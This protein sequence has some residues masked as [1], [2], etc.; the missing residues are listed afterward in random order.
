MIY[1]NNFQEYYYSVGRNSKEE[2]VELR[3]KI[4]K[5]TGISPFSFYPKLLG[6]RPWKDSEKKIIS[7]IV[8]ISISNLF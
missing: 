2:A 1:V 7:K 3:T 8:G 5:K 4:I 6:K